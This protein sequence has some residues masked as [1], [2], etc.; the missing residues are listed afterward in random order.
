MKHRTTNS[1]A[2]SPG[3]PPA[4]SGPR[5]ASAAERFHAH[6]VRPHLER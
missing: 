3:P 5:G 2:D 4:R 6:L 1:P